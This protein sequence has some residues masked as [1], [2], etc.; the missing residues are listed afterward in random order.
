M[1]TQR[2][3]AAAEIRAAIARA[4]IGKAEVARRAGLARQTL[5][6]KLA[7]LT[8]ITLEELTRIAAAVDT[9]PEALAAAACR[10]ARVTK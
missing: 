8:P 1:T 6:R 7:G 3:L 9:P 4:G 2:A 5:S 10:K